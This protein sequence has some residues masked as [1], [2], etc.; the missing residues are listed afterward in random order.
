MGEF[1]DKATQSEIQELQG[2]MTQ[3][4]NQGQG[5][6]SILQ[7]LLGKLPSGLFGGEDQA[8]KVDELQM[9]A[10]AAQMQNTH[11][12]PRQ[13]EEWT[14]YLEDVSSQIYPILEW[15]DEIM[16]TIDETIEKI[17]VLPQLIEQI[18]GN[19]SLPCS[20]KRANQDPDQINI[21][22]FSLLAP[23]IMPIINQVKTELSTGSSEVIQSSKEKQL[24]V[25][26]DDHSTDPTHSMLAK[27]HFSNILVSLRSKLDRFLYGD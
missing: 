27:D 20:F 8:G 11:I 24:I 4:Q 3:S 22:V 21:F 18:Q 19:S 25:F 10:Q 26:K 5:N 6:F 7:D 1:S 17:P 13:P 15:H 23:F 12:T 9:N 2:T 16:Q 14:R